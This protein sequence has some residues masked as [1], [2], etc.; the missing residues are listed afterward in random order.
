VEDCNEL[1]DYLRSRFNTQKVFLVGHSGGTLLGIKTAHKYPEKIHAYV[2]V[3]QIINNYEQQ[4]L[5]YNFIVEQAE[6]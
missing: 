3:A 5:S 4:K 2:G 6:K 1:I